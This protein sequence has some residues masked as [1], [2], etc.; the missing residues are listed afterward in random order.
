MSPLFWGLSSTQAI[1][2]RDKTCCP[3]WPCTAIQ[4][5]VLPSPAVWALLS[6]LGVRSRTEISHRCDEE[7]LKFAEVHVL[8]RMAEYFSICADCLLTSSSALSERH[9]LQMQSNDGFFET[10]ISY[11]ILKKHI[12]LF[13]FFF[14]LF[15][16]CTLFPL[17]HTALFLKCFIYLCGLFFTKTL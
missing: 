4:S 16:L 10:L 15:Y 11:Q 1:Q 5:C 2:K 8:H 17:F 6:L 13:F 3:S 14:F 7:T 12:F 9:N